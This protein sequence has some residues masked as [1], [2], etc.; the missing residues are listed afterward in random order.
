MFDRIKLHFISK[1]RLQERIKQL[2]D[3]VLPPNDMDYLNSL[4]LGISDYYWGTKSKP[5]PR[6]VHG[7]TKATSLTLEEMR[8]M[9]VALFSHLDVRLVYTEGKSVYTLEPI[10]KPKKAKK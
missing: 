3:Q 10:P 6:T 7:A 5:S 4:F 8:R 1:R 2:E 9:L